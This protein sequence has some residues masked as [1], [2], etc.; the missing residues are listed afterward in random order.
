LINVLKLHQIGGGWEAEIRPR[1]THF[2]AK[3]AGAQWLA[4]AASSPLEPLPAIGPTMPPT[5]QRIMPSTCGVLQARVPARQ[6]V[7]RHASAG[8][9]C[10]LMLVS[11]HATHAVEPTPAPAK[12]TIGTQSPIHKAVP[13][14]AEDAPIQRDW[15]DEVLYFLMIDRFAD[16]DPTNNNQGKG[17]YNPASNDHFNGGDLAGVRQKLDYIQGLGV[18]GL[19]ITP[20]MAN[21]WWDPYSKTAGYH[22]YWADHFAEVDKHFGSEADYQALARAMRGRGLRLVQDIV[23]NHTGNFF[24]YEAGWDARDPAK[25]FRRIAGGSHGFAPRQFPF[26]RNNAADEADRKLGIYHW[27]PDVADYQVRNQQLN[28]QMGGLDDLNSENP[29]VRRTLRESHAHWIKSVGVDAFRVDTAFYVA[30]EYLH[31]FMESREPAAPGMSQVWR[32]TG[33]TPFAFGEGWAIDK[34]GEEKGARKIESY[35]RL[36]DGRN[37]LTSMINFPLYGTFGDVFAKGRPPA[38]LA[39]RLAS[40]Q[41]VHKNPALMPTFIDNHDV[42]RFLAGASAAGMKQA[43][44]AML[45]LPGIPVIYYGTEQGFIERRGAMFAAGFGAQGRDHFD[46]GS[47]WYRTVRDMVA[48]RKSERV[49]SRGTVN[50]QRA[51]AVR[52][53]VVAWSMTHEGTT[54]LII[55]NT[56]EYSVLADQV[57]T[58][59]SRSVQ[60]TQRNRIGEVAAELEPDA[61]G[62]VNLILPPRAAGVW[63]SRKAAAESTQATRNTA[64]A[65][66]AAAAA[67]PSIHTLK[68]NDADHVLNVKGQA[69]PGSEVRL[70]IDEDWQHAARVTADA[71]GRWQAALSTADFINGTVSHRLVA[72]D[73]SGRA[74]RAQSFKAQPRWMLMADVSDPANDDKGPQGNYAY[75]TDAGWVSRPGDIRRVQAWSSGGALKLSVSLPVISTGWA[76]Q[77]GFDR[78]AF[79][80]FIS[81]PDAPGGSTLMPLQNASLPE[82]LRWHRRLRVHGW[83]NALFADESADATREG[84]SVSPSAQVSVDSKARTVTFVFPAS[85]LGNRVSLEG[86]RLYLNTWDYD[87]GYRGL[88]PTAS[89]F[90]FGGGDGA[91]DPLMMDDTPVMNLRAVKPAP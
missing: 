58:G 72:A 29:L 33:R 6:R 66:P 12:K 4:L 22:G 49:F 30:P 39:Y 13:G 82:G 24:D 20:P 71:Q 9:A 50:V 84:R 61:A 54:A 78:V 47:E 63:I 57:P 73:S 52:S 23:L 17:E 31:D 83:S 46:I 76:P 27:T 11:M 85:A 5:A 74:S 16:G 32:E 79:T 35:V 28:W 60:W 25:G 88:T 8:I 38:E 48:L 1:T 44:L 67:G 87:A 68:V 56:S 80:L 81:L 65:K 10:M 77:N 37:A 36:P 90:T 86:V 41:R 91:S 64:A 7:L 2:C 55:M 19:W 43:L 34:S 40:M 18:T 26:N 62:R 21:L 51:N 59:A 53:G 89:G 69:A 14:P 75:P 3:L 70:V 42:D 45:T 15:R